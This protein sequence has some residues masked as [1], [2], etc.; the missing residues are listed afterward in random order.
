MEALRGS[1]FLLEA[2]SPDWMCIGK[3]A[4]CMLIVVRQSS[5]QKKWDERTR[6]ILGPNQVLEALVDGAKV[7]GGAAV[8]RMLLG[9]A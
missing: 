2:G 7:G 6:G 1:C 9:I 4:S 5:V 3:R 8:R